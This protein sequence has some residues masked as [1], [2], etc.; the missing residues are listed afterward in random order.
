MLYNISAK[1]HKINLNDHSAFL[2]RQRGGEKHWLLINLYTLWTVKV[3][4]LGWTKWIHY[5]V[6]FVRLKTNTAWLYNRFK[7][8]NCIVKY[9]EVW[10]SF[11]PQKPIDSNTDFMEW[12]ISIMQSTEPS[13]GFMQNHGHLGS[14]LPW[15]FLRWISSVIASLFFVA[16][17]D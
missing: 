6:C 10:E 7:H 17:F 12:S 5:A 2:K 1:N 14:C 13:F 16:A 15:V 8:I 11:A 3:C 4:F 9:L